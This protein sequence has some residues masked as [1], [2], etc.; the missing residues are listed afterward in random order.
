MQRPLL[1][2]GTR[3]SKLAIK[4]A[5]IVRDRLVALHGIEAGEIEIVPMSTAA[6][7]RVDTPLS[8]I[9]GKGLFTQEI[10]QAL[11]EG[12]L[13]LAVHSTKDM[14]TI[15][16]EGLHLA[17]FL[18]RE[19]PRDAFISSKGMGLATLAQ[20]AVIGTSSLRRQA[21]IRHHRPDLQIVPF[22]GNVETRLEKLHKG[23]AEGTFLAVAGLKR[24][25]Y[26]QLITE[27]V[28]PEIMLPAPG[29]GAIAVESRIDDKKTTPLLEGLGSKETHDALTCERA[30]LAALD[31]SCRTPLGGLAQIVG[32]HLD[33]NAAIATPDGTILHRTVL[34][35]ARNEAAKIGEEAANHLRN[36]AGSNF[37]ASWSHALEH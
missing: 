17:A 8:L 36:Q 14:P 23:M 35:G 24:L 2:I 10:E 25:E 34:K 5:L 37:F 19:D 3:S 22:R 16:P 7:R 31:G 4:Q 18:E 26:E 32:E 12:H 20:G 27:I 29:Q 6:D 13:D 1:K 33:F 15:L 11:Q 9:G 28:P 21:F 30:F